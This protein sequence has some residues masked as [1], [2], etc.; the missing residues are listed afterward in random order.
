MAAKETTA[1]ERPKQPIEIESQIGLG[2]G[3][4]DSRSFRPRSQE[5]LVLDIASL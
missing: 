4:G 2:C 3:V 5:V 1:P